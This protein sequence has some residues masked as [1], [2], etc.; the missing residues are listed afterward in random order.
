MTIYP[1]KNSGSGY[2]DP[3]S[4]AGSNY[5]NVTRASV[6]TIEQFTGQLNIRVRGRQMALKIESNQIGCA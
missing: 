5:A 2:T 1:L 6:S 4:V 3:A